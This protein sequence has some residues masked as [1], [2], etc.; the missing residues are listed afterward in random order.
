LYEEFQKFNISEV[1][2]FRKL[3]QQRKVTSEN[4]GSRS[5]NYTINKEGE[6]S[7]DIACKQVHIIDS[8]GYGPPENWDKN[9]RPPWQ[10][11]ENRLYDSRKDHQ[12]NNGG[13]PSRGRGRGQFQEK[14]LYYM[15]HEKDTDH[16]TRDCPIF[17][18]SK[19]KMAQK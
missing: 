15:F 19:K 9:F 6:A 5:F 8:D 18:E 16:R 12:Q 4:K 2:H 7:F 3:D 13:Y 14:P 1:S 17:L 11:S 10:E